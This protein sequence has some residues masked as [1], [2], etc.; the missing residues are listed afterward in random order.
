MAGKASYLSSGQLRAVF[1]NTAQA[2]LAN[3]YI[4]LHTGDPGD[5]GAS[6]VSASGTAYA[7]VACTCGTSGTGAGAVFGG[8]P[9]VANGTNSTNKATLSNGSAITFPVATA[10]WGTVGYFS[11]WDA[12]TAG[13]LL[14]SGAL[15][16]SILVGSGGQPNFAVGALS[17]FE[18]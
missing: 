3:V 14:Y 17:A 9:V 13:N 6:E 2:P 11:V 18:D 1:Q 7:R 10:S 12:A 5:T 8:A 16:S 4:G 15:T